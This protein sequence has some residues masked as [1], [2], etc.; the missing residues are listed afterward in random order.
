MDNAT[1]VDLNGVEVFKEGTHNGDKYTAEDI[2]G[3]VSTFKEL[4]GKLTPKVTITHK[5][6]QD[7]L[8]GLASYGDVV[9]V[10]A[11]TVNG[12]RKLFV[13]LAKVPERVAS[14]IRT[15]RFAERSLVIYK[16]AVIA[17]KRF[18]N[19]LAKV[20][21]LGHE[22]P[23]VEGMAPIEQLSLNMESDLDLGDYEMVSYGYHIDNKENNVQGIEEMRE[24]L[25][26]YEAKLNSYEDVSG[27]EQYLQE[28]LKEQNAKLRKYE[29][30]NREQ[31]SLMKKT[32]V[33]RFLDSLPLFCKDDIKGD[34]K[35]WL[36]GLDDENL[37]FK[38]TKITKDGV[39]E[40]RETQ[41]DLAKRLFTKI[42]K[43]AHLLPV[44]YSEI[45]PA[46]DIER[47]SVDNETVKHQGTKY[48]IEDEDIDREIKD[49]Q[50]KN[51]CDYEQAYYKFYGIE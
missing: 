35:E 42:A 25:K 41:L 47:V 36:Y 50:K 5:E 49:I 30:C 48:P 19:I 51:G 10:Y 44:I 9:N 15:G 26:S 21:L 39:G 24:T 3:L 28:Q 12:I 43:L 22:I 33:D 6:K 14:W 34:M 2:D 32:T 18:K 27:L 37:S 20:S 17:G 7:T 46:G 1:N 40:E 45:V 29:R 8:A 4:E 38:Y 31:A 16:N 11:K 13:D 23:A